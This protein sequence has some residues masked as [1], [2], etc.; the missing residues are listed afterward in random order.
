MTDPAVEPGP[1]GGVTGPG[2]EE[3]DDVRGDSLV[4]GIDPDFAALVFSCL[5]GDEDQVKLDIADLSNL[6]KR[7]PN[8][9]GREGLC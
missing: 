4:P 3:P 6:G 8:K 5:H 1:L 2:E 9:G 7:H